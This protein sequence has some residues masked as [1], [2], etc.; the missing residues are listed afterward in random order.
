MSLR[1][2]AARGTGVAVDVQKATQQLAAPD[3]LILVWLAAC[4]MAH[5]PLSPQ[6]AIKLIA[7]STFNSAS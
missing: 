6:T 1:V 5:Q 7:V 4:D 3:T 2:Q